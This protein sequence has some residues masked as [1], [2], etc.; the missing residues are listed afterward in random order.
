MRRTPGKTTAARER[1][2]TKIILEA[3][4]YPAGITAYC[5]DKNV[6]QNNYYHWFKRLRV[7]HPEWHDL[8]NKPGTGQERKASPKKMQPKTE[9]V[10]KARRRRF[11]AGYKAKVLDEIDGAS[12]GQVAAIL[13]REGLYSSHLQNWRTE[14]DVRAL[15]PKKRGPKV[16]PLA[17]ENKKLKADNARLE[18]KLE[19]ANMLI[20]LQKKVAQIL[21]TTLQESDE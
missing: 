7:S 2:W 12:N 15:E 16:N 4:A 13:R 20:E 6:S 17:N 9:V 1:Y 19:K 5:R 3:R 14:R 21:G 8:A 10:E 11:T 18:R